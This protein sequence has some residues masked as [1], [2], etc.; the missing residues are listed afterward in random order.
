[1]VI[2]AGVYPVLVAFILFLTVSNGFVGSKIHLD[3]CT[4]VF[5][6][7]KRALLC[8]LRDPESPKPV[9]HD[10]MCECRNTCCTSY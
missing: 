2:A 7:Y 5:L 8:R 1:M 4:S 3:T 9:L 6:L 10:V